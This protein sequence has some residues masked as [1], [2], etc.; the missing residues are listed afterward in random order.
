MVAYFHGGVPGKTP[1][2]RLY[3]ANELGLQFEYNLPWFQGNGARYDHNKVYLSSHLGTAIGYAARYRDR[4]GNPLPGWVYEVE[5][6][7]PVEPD[8]DYGAGAIPG[9][10]LYC[11]GAVVVNVIERDVWL[12]EREQNEA[13]WPHLYWEV[14]RPVHAEDGTLLPSDQMLGAGVTQAYVDILP[15]WIGLSEIDG[16]GRMTVEGVSIQPP[17]VLARFDHLNL[18]DRGHIVKITDRRSRPNRLGCTCGGE[19]ADRYAAAGHK[20][21]MDKLAVIAERHQPDGVTQDQLMQLWVNVVAFRSRSQW[22]WFFDHQ[23]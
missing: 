8:P 1:G 12:S 17:D 19:F 23:N 2:D 7:G 9:L 14:D 20:I 13:I 22:R 16:N 10:A 6:V 11:S 3:S 15:K 18:V 4:V 21:D 5:P